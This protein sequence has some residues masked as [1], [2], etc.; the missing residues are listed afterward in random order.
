MSHRK[1]R[2]IAFPGAPPPPPTGRRWNPGNYVALQHGDIYTGGSF[3]GIPHPGVVSNVGPVAAGVAGLLVRPNWKDLEPRGATDPIGSRFNFAPIQSMLDQCAAYPGING[4]NGVQLIVMIVVKSFA[5]VGTNPLPADLQADIGVLGDPNYSPDGYATYFPGGGGVPD[6]YSVWRWNGPV[7][8]PRFAFLVQKIGETFDSHPN[9]AG[10]ATQET[11]TSYVA[12]PAIDGYSPAN[13][14]AG[15]IAESNN[16]STYCPSARH[17]CFINFMGNGTAAQGTLDLATVAAA[18]QPNGAIVAGP[19]LCT[20]GGIVSRCYDIYNAYHFG[21]TVSRT[22]SGVTTNVKMPTKGPTGC[23]VQNDEWTAKS[24]P[25]AD[26]PPVSLRNLYNYATSSFTYTS[27]DDVNALD[28]TP[29]S[30]W[31]SP[32][33]LDIIFWDWHTS[34]PAGTPVFNGGGTPIIA[35]HPTFGTFAP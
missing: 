30:A 25:P 3:T 15:L 31:P 12:Q 35:A 8:T 22:I 16:I 23:S 11:S 14:K 28:H 18:I 29:G 2:W 9:F 33:N 21:T 5:G 24:S 34:G 1:R 6:G 27:A 13:Y 20:Q 4:G 19:D 26:P 10:I 7:I 17:F 32:L